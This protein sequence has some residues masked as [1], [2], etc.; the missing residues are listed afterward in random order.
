MYKSSQIQGSP[1]GVI[2]SQDEAVT[3]EGAETRREDIQCSVCET[4]K[5][6]EDYYV[7][8]SQTGRL[9]KTCKA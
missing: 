1:T 6:I 9:D 3:P 7:K 2:L 5:L 8:D 4:L